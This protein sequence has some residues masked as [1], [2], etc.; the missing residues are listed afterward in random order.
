MPLTKM[1]GKMDC[2]IAAS[3]CGS[4]LRQQSCQSFCSSQSLFF[5]TSLQNP[6]ISE[7][8]KMKG[9][10]RVKYGEVLKGCDRFR[11][12]FGSP[13]CPS[14][15]S[16]SS[17]PPWLQ[18]GTAPDHFLAAPKWRQPPRHGSSHLRSETL[19]VEA[20]C[21][22]MIFHKRAQIEQEKQQAAA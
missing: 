20:V 1:W 16:K 5:S 6:R 21:A 7:G 15:G 12:L 19:G 10:G 14:P 11:L 18:S 4:Q 9:G 13:S 22:E 8:P 17:P 3:D 2:S